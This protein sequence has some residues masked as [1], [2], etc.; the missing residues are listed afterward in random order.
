M[1]ITDSNTSD[2]FILFFP[3]SLKV[4]KNNTLG[5]YNHQAIQ[6][7]LKIFYDRY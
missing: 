6:I 1:S 4:S 3:F 5:M 2:D 7:S